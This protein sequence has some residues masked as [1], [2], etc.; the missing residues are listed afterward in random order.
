MSRRAFSLVELLV[1]VGVLAILAALLFPAFSMARGRARQTAC[2]SN[3]RQLGQAFQL[4][5]TDWER[6]PRGLDAADKFTPSIWAGY[7]N[8]L[9]I[10][11]ETPLLCDLLDS[12]VKDKRTWQCQGD[13]GFDICETTGLPLAARPTSYQA[14]GMSYF[15]RT[16]LM[17]GEKAAED[18]PRPAQTHVLSDADGD[19]HGGFPANLWQGRRYNILYA[20]WHVKS[21]N[22]EGFNAL[23]D[24]DID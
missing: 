11:A 10:M 7:P 8:G 18:L 6:F 4:Y 5:M 23:W 22:G 13:I 19:W 17:L 1:V 9:Q 12:Y 16:E 15:Y 24:V 20:D 2:S 21:V 3:L 14:F